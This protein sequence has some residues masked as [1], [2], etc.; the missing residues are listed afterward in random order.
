MTAA[1][2]TAIA[3]TL[4]IDTSGMHILSVDGEPVVI[5]PSF[6]DADRTFKQLGSDNTVGTIE[7][8]KDCPLAGEVIFLGGIIDGE[9]VI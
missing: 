3:F 2:P 5:T 7:W 4:G 9:R 6:F 1:T 8:V